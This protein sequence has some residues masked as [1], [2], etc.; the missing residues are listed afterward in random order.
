MGL[1]PDLWSKGNVTGSASCGS[2][3]STDSIGL[4]NVLASSGKETESTSC[5]KVIFTGSMGLSPLVTSSGTVTV[6]SSTQFSALVSVASKSSLSAE[7]RGGAALME[8]FWT[9][10]SVFVSSGRAAFLDFCSV[11]RGARACRGVF[12]VHWCVFGCV[13]GV[14]VGCWSSCGWCCSAHEM[15]CV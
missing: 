10:L 12:C 5:G 4:A 13:R 8:L 2:V 9:N 1:L 6:S 15:V 3:A 14:V 7:S 11:C